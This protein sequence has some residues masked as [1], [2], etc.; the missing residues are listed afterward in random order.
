MADPEFRQR[1]NLPDYGIGVVEIS[2]NVNADLIPWART[3]CPSLEFLYTMTLPGGHEITF[4]LNQAAPIDA[5]TPRP[6]LRRL[7]PPTPLSTREQ[8]IVRGIHRL[9]SEN[10]LVSEVLTGRLITAADIRGSRFER[11]F[12]GMI[13]D[14]VLDSSLCRSVEM[15]REYLR[16]VTLKRQNLLFKEGAEVS[17][18]Q[19]VDYLWRGFFDG[20]MRP[21]SATAPAPQAAAPQAPVRAR[22]A[23]RAPHALPRPVAHGVKAQSIPQQG[24][25][26]WTIRANTSGGPI[27]QNTAVFEDASVGAQHCLVEHTLDGNILVENVAPHQV[28][29][30]QGNNHLEPVPLTGARVQS[31]QV[32]QVGNTRLRLV[33]EGR[34]VQVF[35]ERGD[36]FLPLPNPTTSRFTLSFSSGVYHREGFSIRRTGTFTKNYSIEVDASAVVPLR[37]RNG[38]DWVAMT[39]GERH[40][41][42]FQNNMSEEFYLGNELWRI[43]R[44]GTAYL[45]SGRS[46]QDGEFNTPATPVDFTPQEGVSYRIASTPTPLV[47][48][49][50][51]GSHFANVDVYLGNDGIWY[52]RNQSLANEVVVHVAPAG[53]ASSD[54]MTQGRQ[55]P[56]NGLIALRHGQMIAVR[57]HRGNI[58]YHRFLDPRVGNQPASAEAVAE[59]TSL[60]Q[61]PP[62]R[63]LLNQEFDAASFAVDL[64][65]SGLPLRTQANG[66]VEIDLNTLGIDNFWQGNPNVNQ[67]VTENYGGVHAFSHPGMGARSST[68]QHAVFTSPEG[69]SVILGLRGLRGAAGSERAMEISR[70]VIHRALD[71]GQSLE[72]ALALANRALRQ[73]AQRAQQ[74]GQV[75]GD[76]VLAAVELRLHDGS[77]SARII[78][79]GNNEVMVLDFSQSDPVL[80]RNTR[81]ENPEQA[82]GA[83]A[84][85]GVDQIQ[86]DLVHGQMVLVGSGFFQNYGSRERVVEVL[87]ARKATPANAVQFLQEDVLVRQAMLHIA[88]RAQNPVQITR[89]LYREAY[90]LAFNGREMPA[91][92]YRPYAQTN[93]KRNIRNADGSLRTGGDGSVLFDTH[94]GPFYLNRDGQVMSRNRQVLDRFQTAPVTL[95]VQQIGMRVVDTPNRDVYN[96]P[97]LPVAVVRRPAA[98]VARPV[99]DLRMAARSGVDQALP[100]VEG[101]AHPAQSA[102]LEPELPPLSVGRTEQPFVDFSQLRPGKALMIGKKGNVVVGNASNRT[103]SDSHAQLSANLGSEGIRYSIRDRSL[104]GTH[105]FRNG[106]WIDVREYEARHG[107]GSESAFPLQE[108]DFIRCGGEAGVG[109]YWHPPQNVRDVEAA[110]IMGADYKRNINVALIQGERFMLEH[111]LAGLPQNGLEIPGRRAQFIDGVGVREIDTENMDDRSMRETILWDRLQDTVVDQFLTNVKARVLSETGIDRLNPS[112]PQYEAQL[113]R[114]LQIF[115]RELRSAFRPA[116]ERNGQAAMERLRVFVDANRGKPILVG[117]ILRHGFP[118]C[119]HLALVTQAFLVDMGLTDRNDGRRV[120]MQRGNVPGGAHVWNEVPIRGI[121][122]RIIEI[123]QPFWSANENAPVLQP[124]GTEII[125][126]PETQ[127]GMVVR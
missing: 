66:D 22:Q 6:S 64:P 119:R 49:E 117:D 122:R 31:G 108:G 46:V 94:N 84:Q 111:R 24:V 114:V 125:Y 126:N 115:V 71:Q 47:E 5:Q 40:V 16:L 54:M 41:L 123:T 93:L 27:G 89:D 90:A 72:H 87:G 99:E 26:D 88:R 34:P 42:R 102:R 63:A 35:E 33:A 37:R 53:T 116:G 83:Q 62:E 48:G 118:F 7:H 76:A 45:I 67:A 15:C 59:P 12:T 52:L 44:D 74:Q 101:A 10:R 96:I 86:R 9:L 14:G 60:D 69:G 78:S 18:S 11:E 124:E 97:A 120:V 38:S 75:V 29:L 106:D 8:Q 1:R 121:L 73:D 32:I 70:R 19:N 57:E 107:R 113:H 77:S 81:A 103:V 112:D 21:L 100:I 56:A 36:R 110:T 105:V 65:N 55:V 3:H 23:I 91:E 127:P 50:R 80:Y 28:F 4:P 85:M 95:I 17:V 2:G 39:P 13:R 79:N 104:N 58:A 61:A 68:T 20:E 30:V 25:H 51:S 109:F 82:L 98:P 92:F 43:G